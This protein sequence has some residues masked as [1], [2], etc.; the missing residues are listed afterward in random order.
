MYVRWFIARKHG[1]KGVLL[2]NVAKEQGHDLVG[3]RSVRVQGYF[4]SET[5]EL[6]EIPPEWAIEVGLGDRPNSRFRWF[7]WSHFHAK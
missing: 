2:T 5:W 4:R 6:F 3:T 7:F 1:Y